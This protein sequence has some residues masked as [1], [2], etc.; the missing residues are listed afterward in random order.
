[1]KLTRRSF[2][3]LAGATALTTV[4]GKLV[5][6]QS[7]SEEIDEVKVSYPPTMAALPLVKG[8]QDS[9]FLEDSDPSAFKGKDLKISL[10]PSK[11]P[12]DAARLVSGG[13]ADCSI[14][15][16]ASAIYG[17]QGTGNLKVVSSAFDPNQMKRYSGLLTSNLYEINT[18][19]DLVQEW[20]DKSGKKS[21]VLS[22][23]RDEHYSTDKLI[24]MKGIAINDSSYYL[25]GEDLVS[26]MTGLLNGNY[27]SAVLPEPLLTLALENPEFEGHL[28]NLLQTYEE[29][30]IPPFV[31]VFNQKFLENSPELVQK[32]YESWGKAIKETNKSNNLQLLGLTTEIITGTFPSL[33]QAVEETELGEEFA[34]LFEVPDFPQPKSLDESVYDSVMDWIIEKGFLSNRTSYEELTAGPTIALSEEN[35]D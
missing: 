2:I 22:K 7:K 35:D 12:S 24:K 26:R 33:K 9:F 23:R 27:I 34:N 19:E 4:P 15:D 14:T 16:L 17:V 18:I 11:S 6:S 13:K 21:I 5:F 31:F 3:K 1:M 25:D 20:L 8:T 28:A 30:E 29:V 32:F 10:I